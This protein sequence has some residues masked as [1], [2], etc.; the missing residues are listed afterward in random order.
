MGPFLIMASQP[1]GGLGCPFQAPLISALKHLNIPV[2]IHPYHPLLK[3]KPSSVFCKNLFLK[4]RKGQFYLVI[5]REENCVNLKQLKT[6]LGACRNFS[7]ASTDE[8]FYHLGVLPG[9]V[10]PF[11]LLGNHDKENIRLVIDQ[12]LRGEE[13]L[14]FHPLTPNQTCLISFEHLVKFITVGCDHEME[15]L[16]LPVS[17]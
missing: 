9:A 6:D 12:S 17:E 13:E 16:N 11:A 4:D 7:F 3:H 2:R 8:L 14:N 5:T 1:T 10:T 15:F